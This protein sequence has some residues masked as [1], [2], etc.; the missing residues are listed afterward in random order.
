MSRIA[1]IVAAE[2]IARAAD[3]APIEATTEKETQEEGEN[4]EKGER[5]RAPQTCFQKFSDFFQK[6]RDSQKF[7]E[8]RCL[9]PRHGISENF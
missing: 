7:S 6:F 3:D 9:V 5:E 8:I 4:D 1:Q 2:G